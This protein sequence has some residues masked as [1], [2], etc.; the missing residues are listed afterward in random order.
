MLDFYNMSENDMIF[1]SAAVAAIIADGLTS[2]EL[3]T[4]GSFITCVGDSLSAAGV[5]KARREEREK[6]NTDQKRAVDA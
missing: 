1:L 6:K 4:L 5:Q 3:E 2:D